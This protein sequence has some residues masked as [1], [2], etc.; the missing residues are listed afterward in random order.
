[1][2]VRQ[3]EEL[4]PF[5]ALDALT[6]EER[7]LVEEYLIE[8]PEARQQVE[9]MS[10]T[11]SA[12]PQGV[13]PVD[14]PRR[15]K[16]ALLARVAADAKGRARPSTQSQPSRRG[17]RFE[18]FFRTFSLVTAAVAIVWVILL[19]LQVARLR[20]EIT[21]L[22]ER[23]AAQSDSLEKII[24]NLPQTNPSNVI[25]VSLKGTE[26][27]PQAQ[28]QLLVNPNSQSAVLVIAGLSQLEAGKTYQI[29]LID[30]GAPVSA[31]LLTVDQNG[32]GVFVVTSEAEIGSF[33][34]LGISVEPEGGSPQPTGDI[35][36]LSDL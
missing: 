14:P 3:I 31:G 34:S 30:G 32:Q 23:L 24:T 7:E 22:N 19:N 4:L 28:G 29:W 33:N 27:Q 2:D 20:S 26:V 21:G 5:Y 36:V 17:M 11:A 15:V 9:Q 25:T 16:Q 13:A 35:V 12:L 18:N 8:H 1:M 10:R 6:D